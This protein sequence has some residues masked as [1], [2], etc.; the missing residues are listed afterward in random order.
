VKIWQPLKATPPRKPKKDQE[1]ADKGY[2]TSW[3]FGKK[4]CFKLIWEKNNNVAFP[5]T[6]DSGLNYDAWFKAQII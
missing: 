6:Y 1:N 3:P 2:E 4:T 5:N